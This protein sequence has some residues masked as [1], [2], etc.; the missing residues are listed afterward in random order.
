MTIIESI[1]CG[2]AGSGVELCIVEVRISRPRSRHEQQLV[3]V[4]VLRSKSVVYARRA[5]ICGLPTFGQSYSE[6]KGE[7]MKQR[8]TPAQETGKRPNVASTGA[9]KG[10]NHT[11]PR[12]IIGWAVALE[13]T[14]G[15]AVL[16]C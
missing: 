13:R 9:R 4:A 5:S 2:E 7:I 16:Q 1:P 11:H 12:N 3:V 8:T 15:A 14:T 6:H 10:L